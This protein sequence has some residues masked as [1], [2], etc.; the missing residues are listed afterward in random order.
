GVGSP[1]DSSQVQVAYRSQDLVYPS[2]L[3][4]A[5]HCLRDCPTAASMAAYFT[6]G[7][8][9]SSPFVAATA[10]NFQPTLA[11]NLVDYTSDAATALLLDGAA[12]PVVVNASRD[13]LDGSPQFRNG[14]RTG[15]LFVNLS[16]AECDVGS[17]T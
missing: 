3:P 13:A 7:S 11:V 5:L 9:A 14:V 10:N 6:Q 4:A 15:K 17:G 1:V 16:D 2:Q 8:Q 12:A